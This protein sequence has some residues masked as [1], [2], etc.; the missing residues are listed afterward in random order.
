MS[1]PDS[2]VSI[3]LSQSTALTKVGA[4]SLVARGRVDLRIKEETEE[5]LKRGLELRCQE[6]YEEA[7][8]CFERGIEL[9]PNH[10]EIQF[11]LGFSLSNGQGVSKDN[12]EA[13]AWYRKAA[14]QGHPWAQCNLGWLYGIG[15]PSEIDIAQAAA[16]YRKAAEKGQADSTY[17]LSQMY[18]FSAGAQQGLE[19][20]DIWKGLPT[21][22]GHAIA[23]FLIGNHYHNG[24]V[25]QQDDAEAAVW[26][27]RA[28]EL[29]DRDAQRILGDQY[30][31]GRGVLQDYAEAASWYR[32]AAH[33]GDLSSQINLAEMYSQGWVPMKLCF[34]FSLEE[35]CE[36]AESLLAL[37]EDTYLRHGCKEAAAYWYGKA[38]QQGSEI[39]A[40]ALAE[41]QPLLTLERAKRTIFWSGAHIN[42][43]HAEDRK[44]HYAAIQEAV[45][46]LTDAGYKVKSA[47]F[48]YELESIQ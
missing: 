12:A 1:E 30:R 20:D 44:R 29:E 7:F 4:K 33:K 39:A 41:L 21:K 38:T 27:R 40:S 28:A 18:A 2:K 17:S 23:Q 35:N 46:V 3:V 13:A 47:G 10:P 31:D 42:F 25:V 16:W 15:V 6:K 48:G 8:A 9:N 45:K 22:Y 26:Y 24:W 11:A 32:K 34:H 36:D 43:E 19:H 5:R 37:D 14:E